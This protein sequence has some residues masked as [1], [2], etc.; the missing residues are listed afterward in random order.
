MA[1]NTTAT[2]Q[3]HNGTGSQNNFA[4]SFAFLANTEVDVTV[5]GVLKT[6]GTH[7]NIVGSQV[8]F[9]SGNTPPSGTAN[10]VFT[11]DTDIS[12]KKVDF[13]DG[14]VLTETDLDNNGNQILFGL[15]EIADDYVKRD[16]TQTVKGNL[17]FEGATDD[18]NETTLAITDPTA[19]RTITL[20][21]RSGTVI[22]S[23]DTGTV[24]STMIADGTIVDADVNASAAISGSKLQAASGSN[25]GSMSASDKSKLDSI[26]ANATADQNAADIQSLGFFTTSN[27]GAGSGFD[28]DLLDGSHGSSYLRS[29]TVDTFTGTNNSITF[30]DTTKLKFGSNGNLSIH[31]DGNNSYITQTATGQTYLAFINGATF[32]TGGSHKDVVKLVKTGAGANTRVHVELYEGADDIAAT[33]KR[34]ETTSTGV[35][36]F[37]ETKTTS[38]EINGTDVTSTSN[39]INILDGATLNT[40]ELNKLDGVTASTA[41]LNLLS[42]KSIVTSIAGNATDVQIPSAQA[43]NER[44][45]ELVTEVG[46]FHPI[47]NETSFPATNP[48]INDGAGT[49]VSLKA[50]SNS[51]STGS[52]VTTHTFTNGAGSGNNVTIN[53]LPASTTFQAGKGLLLETTST[54]HTYTYHRLVLD[55]SGVSNADALVTNFNERYY[56]ALSSNPATRPSGANRQDGDLYF[57]NSDNKMKVYNGTHAS[58]TWDDVAAPANF[59]INTLSSS[60]GSG[61]GQAA[62]NSNATRFTLSNPPTSA[63]QLL[64]SINGVIQKPNSGTSPSEGFAVDGN[65]IIFASAPATN[66]PFFIVTIGSSVSI[67]TPSDNTVTSA[68]IVDGSI[69]NADIS[70]SAAIQ[71]TKISPNFGSQNISTTGTITTG[72][73]VGSGDLLIRPA[74][75]NNSIIMQSNNGS[76]TLLKATVN[77]AVEL[78]HGTSTSEKKFE[79]DSNGVTVTGTLR[80]DQ[81]RLGDGEYGYFGDNLDLQIYHDGNDS[82]ITDTGTGSLALGGSAVFIQNAAHDANMASFIAGGETNLFH[83]GD[84][85]FETTSDGA[86]VSSNADGVLNLDTSASNG[87]FMRFGQGGTFHNMVGC[88]DGITSGDKEDLGI[89]GA[90]NIIFAAGGSTERVRIQSGGGISFNG[91]TTANNALDDYEE[92]GWSALLGGGNFTATQQYMKYTKIGRFVILSGEFSNFSSTTNG[93]SITFTGAPFA[94]SSGD[95]FVGAINTSAIT[96]HSGFTNPQACRIG[97]GTTTMTF[98]YG[99]E[100]SD[101]RFSV[102]YSDLS[103]SSVIQFTLTYMTAT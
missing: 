100:D 12:A 34:L 86:T 49:I 17:V 57:N 39:E 7:Y 6:L 59:F 32:R 9:T 63:A 20:P 44:V 90:D 69:V 4:I 11:R 62:F 91:D 74:A 29:D 42:G 70:S 71:G 87:A 55:E 60:S 28:A 95:S 31:Y 92:G 96:K 35:T 64:V 10:V 3:N 38:L 2:T 79:T 41:E 81:F 47:A 94:S 67:G 65:D 73:V 89:R 46:G 33:T 93:T 48:D 85:R 88:A 53:G 78:Y 84:K 97:E 30:A 54:L 77:G 40:N 66:A 103:S 83:N 19:D 13:A 24:T 22:T 98:Q 27:D 58:G 102:R 26:E 1:T 18:G 5:G 21:D 56:G 8:Q 76:E 80:T 15:Q 82:K 45:V 37:G 101:T 75:G 14:S 43:V 68:K 72:T 36:I 51:F 52:G 16:G 25:A 61:G 50:L 99:G 23:G